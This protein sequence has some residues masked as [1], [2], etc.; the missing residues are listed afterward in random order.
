MLAQI[1]VERKYKVLCHENA[2]RVLAQLLK[3]LTYV[4]TT[5]VVDEYL[6]TADG[7][8]Y[9]DG[10]FIRVRNA[11]M[12]DIKFNPDHVGVTLKEGAYEPFCHEYSF[13]LPF[14]VDS[15]ALFDALQTVIPFRKPAS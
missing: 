12:L 2:D 8:Y 14:K 11:S 4:K 10:I 9:Q 7:T 5:R 3:N 15:E 1:E 6:D 13:P